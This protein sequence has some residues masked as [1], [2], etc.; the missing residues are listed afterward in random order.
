MKHS[1]LIPVLVLALVPAA[2]AQKP[3]LDPVSSA[4]AEPA[5]PVW[6]EAQGRLKV[7]YGTEMLFEGT[8]QVRATENEEFRAVKPGEVLFAPAVTTG[9]RT[10]QSWSF[11]AAPGSGVGELQLSGDVHTSAE[12]LAAEMR[13]AAQQRFPLV[14]TSVGQSRNLRNDAIY[15]RHWDWLLSAKGGTTRIAQAKRNADAQSFHLETRGPALELDFAPLW[16]QRHRNLPEYR[17][18]TYR[19]FKDSVSGWCSWWAYR[20]TID[21]KKLE[22][23]ADALAAQHMNEF[24]LKWLQID[25]GYQTGKGLPS[26]WLEWNQKFEG[27]AEATADLIQKRG[28]RPGIWVY[29]AFSD[30]DY[31]REHADWFVHDAQGALVKGPWVDFGLDANVQAA[32]DAVV[33]PTYRG[34]K[35][36]GFGYVK[37]DSLRHLLYDAYNHAIPALAKEGATP[38]ATLRK[39]LEA[40]RKA[41]GGETYLLACWGVLPEVIGVADGCRLGGDGFGP[42]TLQQYNSWN[43]LVWRNDPDHCDVMPSWKEVAGKGD[44]AIAEA[45]KES[46]LRP[47]LASMAGAVLMLSDPAEVYADPRNLEG[48][49]RALPVL[50]SVPGQTYDFDARKT[51]ALLAGKRTNILS[52]KDP[53]PIDADQQGTLAPWWLQEIDRSFEHW[54]VL[55]RFDTAG[56]GLAESDVR[57]EDLGLEPEPEYLVYEFWS[58][59]LVPVARSGFRAPAAEQGATQVFAIREKLDHPQLLSTSRHISQGAVELSELAW[60]PGTL[61]LEGVS[62]LIA[63]DPYEVTVFVPKGWKAKNSRIGVSETETRIDGDLARFSLLPAI[64]QKMF[65]TISFEKP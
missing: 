5:A 2:R 59:R 60:N 25:D 63:G 8:L 62:D 45:R 27:G 14:R 55:A 40:V 32:L 51:D 9:E 3:E 52:G 26:G 43:G 49:K 30:A 31:A 47:T 17:P 22:S 46:I 36:L 50:F 35:K 58:K 39:Y 4:L 10:D 15:D 19:V 18:W 41:L 38:Q 21:S 54:N 28:F 23:V 44:A 61:A 42:A 6:D 56:K 1:C 64:S 20:D 34:L 12:G 48:A 7:V 33:K 13:G 11:E 37:V 16:M 29:S 24:G 53:S 57:F 65:W